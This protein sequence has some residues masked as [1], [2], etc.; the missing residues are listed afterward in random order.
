MLNIVLVASVTIIRSCGKSGILK[1]RL[2]VFVG[3]PNAYI[4]IYIYIVREGCNMLMEGE[5]ELLSKKSV[6]GRVTK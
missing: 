4:Y 5:D 2:F 3:H 6:D 1:F